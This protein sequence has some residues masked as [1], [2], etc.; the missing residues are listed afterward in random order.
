MGS[1]RVKVCDL[2]HLVVSALP[3]A[4]LFP[5]PPLA[6]SHSLPDAPLHS[7]TSAPLPLSHSLPR[8]LASLRR[9]HLSLSLWPSHCLP[10]L[11]SAP[12]PW[13]LPRALSMPS[14]PAAAKQTALQPPPRPAPRT[15][16]DHTARLVGA[17]PAC[18]TGATAAPARPPSA[19]RQSPPPRRRPVRPLSL[20]GAG[21][22]RAARWPCAAATL[23][24]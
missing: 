13:P 21:S 8:C 6:S 7:L 11:R 1:D 17:S 12:V 2:S 4:R 10:L 14:C 16:A 20:A 24:L 3:L 19:I 5:R 18:S 23:T 15:A 22:P 9:L